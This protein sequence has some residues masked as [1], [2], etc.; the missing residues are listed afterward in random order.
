MESLLSFP[1]DAY[2]YVKFNYGFIGLLVGGLAL[3]MLALTIYFWFD[4]RKI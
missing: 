1:A 3:V 4:R 2:D